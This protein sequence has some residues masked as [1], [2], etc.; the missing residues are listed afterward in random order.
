MSE[1]ASQTPCICALQL[2]EFRSHAALSL[3]PQKP[4][5]A[6]CGRNGVGK[7]NIL[8][9]LSL[10]SPGRGMRRAAAESMALRGGSGGFGVH[11]T[12][13]DAYGDVQMGTGLAMEDGARVRRHRRQGEPVTSAS[14]FAQD[15]RP[16][17]L[18]PSMDG[19]FTGSPSERRRFLDR[20]V[21]TLDPDHAARVQAFE[22]ALSSRNRLLEEHC[23][24]EGWLSA[25]ER[26]IAEKGIA[27]TAAR[28]DAVER[29]QALARGHDA[30]V[31]D[32][33]KARM[34]LLGD[35]DERLMGGES[36]A[37]LEDW[38]RER[39]AQNRRVDAASG[40]AKIGPQ[41]SDLMVEHIAKN[42][43][44][45]QCS[46][47]EQKALLI[48]LVLA[49]AAMVRQVSEVS[50]LLLLD[51]VVAHL[52]PI[53]RASLLEKLFALH[54]PVWMTGTE[55]LFFDGFRDQIELIQIGG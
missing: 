22:R 39:L 40:R 33:P 28:L 30:F 11:L 32:F 29:L 16:I 35:L 51:E 20:M 36:A 55:A 52:D 3:S 18:L 23:N 2:Q 46:T 9:A 44:A 24:D 15:L 49:H 41:T 7:T 21:L 31:Q 10:F 25:L 38:Y 17:W 26:E 19:L 1:A 6:L 53:R 14:A 5:V 37:S 54:C 45:E 50:P 34:V 48:G 8:E 13:R 43:P 42:M 12:L 47:G 27:I 4:M